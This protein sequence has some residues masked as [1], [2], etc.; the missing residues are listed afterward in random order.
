MSEIIPSLKNSIFNNEVKDAIKDLSEVTVDSVMEDGLLKDIPIVRTVVALC[1][2][3]LNIK[4]RNFI[5]Q[6][7]IFIKQFNDGSLSDEQ[8]IEHYQEL[9]NNPTL[10]EKEMNVIINFLSDNNE[11][12]L[13]QISGR[14][15]LA[16][17]K[18]ALSW[19]KFGE[20]I[21]VNRR[22]FVGDYRVLKSLDHN[23]SDIK[24]K[25][26]VGRLVG[27]GLVVEYDSPAAKNSFFES[28]SKGTS[29]QKALASIYRPDYQITNLGKTLLQ[30]VD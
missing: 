25:Y 30:F 21:E 24:E 13:S 17:V 19:S 29:R 9:N 22:M 2:T 1:K 28:F 3:G 16:Y 23:H 27:L 26:R 20:L 6:T 12:E 8:L 14:L 10:A 7:I 15:Y 18:G 11:E 4:E 5:R